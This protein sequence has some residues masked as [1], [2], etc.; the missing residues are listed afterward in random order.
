MNII[1]SVAKESKEREKRENNVVIFGVVASTNTDQK[2]EKEENKIAINKV[3][4]KLQIRVNI[5]NIIKLKSKSDKDN[6]EKR[7]EEN[8]V[9]SKDKEATFKVVL[10][11]REERDLILKKAKEL[12]DSKE[13]GNLFINPYQTQAERYKSKLLRDE[14]KE[15]NADNKEK[16][17]YYYGIRN[18]KVVKIFKKY[19]QEEDI[20]YSNQD[21]W[22]IVKCYEKV[23]ESSGGAQFVQTS[24][25]DRILLEPHFQENMQNELKDI[26]DLSKEKEKEKK[27]KELKIWYTNA[28][29]LRTIK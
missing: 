28:T 14:P 27:N 24:L 21:N 2:K 16:D 1:N 22:E 4:N 11:D 8:K 10:K 25:G 6:E 12:R 29:S 20:I 13:Y 19:L 18:D 3:L 9:K 5:E 26:F 23:E 17:K 7:D 15:K